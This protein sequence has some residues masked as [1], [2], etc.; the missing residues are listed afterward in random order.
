MPPTSL[1]E[2]RSQIAEF[3][4]IDTEFENGKRE[5]LNNFFASASSFL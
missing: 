2:L 3:F 4:F 1:E 5:R